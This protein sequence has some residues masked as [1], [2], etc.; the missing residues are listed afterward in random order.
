MTDI[1]EIFNPKPSADITADL[2]EWV[3][4]STDRLT[5]FNVGGVTR[6]LL[7]AHAEELDDY[8]QAIYFGL[9]K[10]IPT[11]IYTGFGFDI[12][13]AVAATG[14]VVFS[15]VNESVESVTIPAGTALM[16]NNGQRFVTLSACSLEI[17]QASA[18][19]MV[20]ALVV[21]AAGNVPANTLSLDSTNLGLIVG[22]NPLGTGGGVD[23]ETE[24]HRAERF[25]AFVR[26]LARGTMA[27]LQ[28]IA[29][30]P[31]ITTDDGV[32]I[33]RVQRQSVYE[34]PGHVMLYVDNGSWGISDELLAKV[35]LAVDGYRDA[36]TLQWVGGYR[37]A[38]MRVEVAA[39]SR[40]AFNVSL[41]IRR[42]DLVSAAAVE[43]DLLARMT[44][45][46]AGVLPLQILRMIDLINVALSVTGVTAV[47]VLSPDEN[48]E[49][50]SNT[51]LYLNTLDIQWIE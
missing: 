21:G 27:S 49:V 31:A 48:V 5:D 43:T 17:G 10:A 34:E 47:T 2:I 18:S 26:S 35:Q 40:Q 14:E 7:E 13:P 24:D 41:E 33:E 45:F 9:L 50:P 28:Y 19:T 4:G 6:T 11:A 38:G 29:G 15:R 37:P 36:D 39:M 46:L 22:T 25:A 51:I 8:Y 32:V 42:S 30:I 20:R 16:A 1:T 12:Q 23:V 3:R 44:T